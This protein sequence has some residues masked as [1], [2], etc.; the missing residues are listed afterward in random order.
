MHLEPI[1]TESQ[2]QQYKQLSSQ[3]FNFKTDYWPFFVQCAG[4]ENLRVLEDGD[5]VLGGLA[6]Y[7]MGQW[8]GG[9]RLPMAGFALVVARPERRGQG[10]ARRMMA[11]SIQELASEFP[12][13][14][15][16]ASTQA[17]YRRVGFEQAGTA[18]NYAMPIASLGKA[19]MDGM[20]AVDPCDHE[21][22]RDLDR[23]RARTSDGC[24]DRSEGMWHRLT[25][26]DLH[27]PFAYVVQY[28]DGPEGF[29]IFDQQTSNLPAWPRYDKCTVLRARDLVATTP[30][31]YD[32]ILAF[33]AGQRS[34]VDLF[35]WN[36]PA[37]DPW[38]LRS[39]EN[40]AI[41]AAHRRWLLRILDV[42]RALEQR[43]YRGAD[44]ELH[45]EV[46]DDLIEA[47]CGRFLLRVEQGSG[48]VE[49]GGNG[50][51]RLDISALAPLF[52]G[53][54]SAQALADAGKLSA[55]NQEEIHLASALFASTESWMA[56]WF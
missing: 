27:K 16:Y 5:T 30:R 47:N 38:L 35:S 3:A 6:I 44:G 8:F 1:S 18:N 41:V 48:R 26:D 31:A 54:L 42:R 4:R 28:D 24:L 17:L 12:I 40:H 10:V 20:H 2:E 37:A 33:V 56:D 34:I 50:A 51:V 21:P 29:L 22:F 14:T 13:A 25:R 45:L 23:Q 19:T 15:L 53:Y 11:E 7:R 9:K 52:T 36:G 43:G 46:H 32:S 49:E 39:A 55:A